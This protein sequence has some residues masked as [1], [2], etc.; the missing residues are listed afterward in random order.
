MNN[1]RLLINQV[2]FFGSVKIVNVQ[3]VAKKEMGMGE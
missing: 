2:D 1:L 3:I